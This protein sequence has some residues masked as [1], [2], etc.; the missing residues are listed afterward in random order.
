MEN[1]ILKL[2]DF[3]IKPKGHKLENAKIYG[4]PTRWNYSKG[5]Q[6]IK[7]WRRTLPKSWRDNTNLSQVL[8]TAGYPNM[9]YAGYRNVFWRRVTKGRRKGKIT[10]RISTYPNHIYFVDAR[11][12]HDSIKSH[13]ETLKAI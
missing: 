4:L 7:E 6:A 2:P 11:V 12:F 9:P 8:I 1:N 13:W 5:K 3:L 10:F